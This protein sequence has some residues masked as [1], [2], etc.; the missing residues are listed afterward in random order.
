MAKLPITHTSTIFNK[1]NNLTLTD[2][3]IPVSGIWSVIMEDSITNI[4]NCN[5]ENNNTGGV[6][7]SNSNVTIVGSNIY[8]KP[9]EKTIPVVGIKNSKIY[10][11][12]P[13]QTESNPYLITTQDSFEF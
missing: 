6:I 13:K 3:N 4:R 11:D 9:S 10:W 12:S 7:A 2:P 8:G 5:I 1:R